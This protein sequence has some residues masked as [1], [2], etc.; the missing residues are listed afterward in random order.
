MS[1]IPTTQKTLPTSVVESDAKITT[2]KRENGVWCLKKVI[3]D[4]CHDLI[5]TKARM[6]N[7]NKSISLHVKRTFQVND[8]VGVRINKTFQSLA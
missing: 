3:I 8:D 1:K 2:S 4:Q 5:P 7:V 6:F